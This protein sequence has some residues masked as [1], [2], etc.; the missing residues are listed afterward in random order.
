VFGERHDLDF[1]L[2]ENVRHELWVGFIE[3]EDGKMDRLDK[4]SECLWVRRGAQNQKE[5]KGRGGLTYSQLINLVPL[6]HV[7]INDFDGDNLVHGFVFGNKDN[8]GWTV[9]CLYGRNTWGLGCWVT[10][11]NCIRSNRGNEGKE[12]ER[13]GERVTEQRQRVDW[14]EKREKERKERKSD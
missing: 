8:G 1:A 3:E 4:R 10:V 14:R 11:R 9:A 13:E 6:K 5:K 2:K 7:Q 12:M